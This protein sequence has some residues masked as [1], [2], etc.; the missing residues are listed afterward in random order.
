MP[1]LDYLFS[2]ILPWAIILMPLGA[3]CWMMWLYTLQSRECRQLRVDNY[4]LI[5]RLG[6]Y[7]SIALTTV[8]DV[9]PPP[10]SEPSVPPA[11]RAR[12]PTP[13]MSVTEQQRAASRPP[14]PP[15]RKTR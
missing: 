10:P 1:T 5:H 2:T 4:R 11:F 3:L 8:S 7:H 14:T 12:R 15:Q 9:L 6:Q 13:Q